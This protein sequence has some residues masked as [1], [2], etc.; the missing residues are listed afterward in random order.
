MG[1]K[2][3]LH[4]LAAGCMSLA[5]A[6]TAVDAP[7]CAFSEDDAVSGDGQYYAIEPVDDSLLTYSSY[8]D[9]YSGETFPDVS[10]DISGADFVSASGD[11]DSGSYTDS[12]GDTRE[13]CLIWESPDGEVSYEFEIAETG[14]YCVDMSYCP[15]DTGTSAIELSMKIDGELPYDTASRISLGRVWVNEKDIYTDSRGNQVRPTQVQKEM[16][17]ESF[18]GD[19]DG[20]FNEPL[21]VHLKLPSHPSGHVS[22]WIVSASASPK[23]YLIIKTSLRR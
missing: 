18:F 11:T 16:W 1:I 22:S 7:L 8:Y 2:K 14:N 23:L 9:K 15:I 10:V 20:L 4:R 19:I 5:A 13:D 17:Q 6:V 12:D 21:F 3:F